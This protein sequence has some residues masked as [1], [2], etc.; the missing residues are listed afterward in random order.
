MKNIFEMEDGL[1]FV[2][3]L[4]LKVISKIVYWGA[5][6]GTYLK[7]FR[8]T[9]PRSI[10]V[11]CFE[12]NT[13]ERKFAEKINP[14]VLFTGDVAI[15]DKFL[16]TLER[17][18]IIFNGSL[19]QEHDF[20]TVIDY[21]KKFSAIV[22][23]DVKA[24]LVSSEPISDFTRSRIASIAPREYE[25][26]TKVWGPVDDKEHLYRFFLGYVSGID[27]K[28]DLYDVP[29]TEIHQA[30]EA[31][32]SLTYEKTLTSPAAREAI[33]EI[34]NHRMKDTTHKEMIFLRDDPL[35]KD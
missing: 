16:Y 21:M 4:N 28:T 13:A 35:T 17:K 34:F 14:G 6:D 26:F 30:L 25:A 5:G 15:L 24:P 2:N 19:H 31:D 22:I 11:L 23:Y 12:R 18:L 7:R 8:E 20:K 1:N 10:Q 29:W 27:W 33:D 9:L 32:Y 3:S